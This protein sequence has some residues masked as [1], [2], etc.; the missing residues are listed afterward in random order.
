[1]TPE[2][3]LLRYIDISFLHFLDVALKDET[4]RWKTSLSRAFLRSGIASFNLGKYAEAKN[5]FQK[6]Q[7]HQDEMGI[8]QWITWCDEKMKK[9]GIQADDNRQENAEINNSTK[10]DE[11]TKVETASLSEL[12][13]ESPS[14]TI[15]VED[16]SLLKMPIPKIKH[17]WYQTETQ[18]KLAKLTLA[19][20]EKGWRGCIIMLSDI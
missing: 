17:D 16:D 8:K 7:Q 19:L 1:M 14:N 2:L 4:E 20:W 18:V 10:G 11:P 12:K 6:G 3:N 5:C 9:L 15:M 13:I